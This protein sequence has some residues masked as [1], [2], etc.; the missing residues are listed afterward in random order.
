[1]NTYRLLS[2]L[3]LLWAMPGVAFDLHAGPGTL[4]LDAETGATQL[5]VGDR[6]VTSDGPQLQIYDFVADYTAGGGAPIAEPGALSLLA[7]GAAGAVGLR[8]RRS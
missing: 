8:R 6:Q 3:L 7:L 5:W 4:H 1:M 2:A